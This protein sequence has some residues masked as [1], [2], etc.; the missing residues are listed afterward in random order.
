MSLTDIH[1][2]EAAEDR[3]KRSP[4]TL[5]G[6]VVGAGVKAFYAA[7]AGLLLTCSLGVVV[8]AVTPSSGSGP[9]ALLRAGV[10]AFSAANGMT[11]TIG[12]AA[13][14][15]PPLMITLVAI[16][17]LTTVSGRGRA[18]TTDRGQELTSTG[19]A[20]VVY[21]VVVT[22]CAVVLGPAGAVA[23]DQWWRPALLALVVVGCTTLVRGVGWRSYLGHMLPLWVPVS[24][25]LGVAGTA[26]LIG[27]GGVT[28]V[29]ALLRSWNDA[30]T[31]ASLAAP[32][33]GGG[34]GMA[35]LGI[36]YLP[37]AVVAGA[38]YASGVG[39]TVGN[40]NYSPFGSSPTELP[41]VTLLTAVP[42]GAGYATSALLILVL[43]L[44]AAVFMGRGA[45]RRLERRK[46]RM[47][48]V[49]AAALFAGIAS[50]LL[51]TV[52]SGG[53][54]GGAWSSIGVPPLPFA[55][56][57]TV[58][59]GV[60]G[61][62]VAALGRVSVVPEGP[63]AGS[64]AG[65]LAEDPQTIAEVVQDEEVSEP[66]EIIAAAQA[67]DI[68]ERTQ[69]DDLAGST[70]AD[71]IAGANQIDKGEA[72]VGEESEPAGDD[73]TADVPD[74]HPPA[75]DEPDEVPDEADLDQ[76]PVGPK[77]AP[78]RPEEAP[79]ALDEAPEVADGAP[80]DARE[81]G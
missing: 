80:S 32:G 16:A 29:I 5:S 7:V 14:T 76:A 37:N 6:S 24:V 58:G 2:R 49:A 34:F 60:V 74:P 13:L 4:E 30:T 46:D 68:A 79:V 10:A 39:F 73:R 72:P 33:A 18:V 61:V 25:R 62:G 42:D 21:S 23:A 27:A 51:A 9:V 66:G 75:Q 67:D 31:V 47:F 53:V 12:H 55:V 11:V 3:E 28:V 8:W 40:G 26:A 77:E 20:A 50:C 52:A 22:S 70:P 17:L 54:T 44:L 69:V 81:G 78:V 1:P 59:L 64:D 19:I 36:A 57:V 48:A 38:G 43:P 15:M 41:A 35:L 63:T 71:D 45:V 65:E 56:A